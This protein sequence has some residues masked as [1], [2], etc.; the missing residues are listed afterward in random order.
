MSSIADQQKS[1]TKTESE[2]KDLAIWAKEKQA[3]ETF[4]LFYVE[5][6]EPFMRDLITN[7]TQDPSKMRKI[8]QQLD[9]FGLRQ[10]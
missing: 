4:A 5:Q 9:I 2:V 6:L 7:L 8:V 1:L 10:E 3:L